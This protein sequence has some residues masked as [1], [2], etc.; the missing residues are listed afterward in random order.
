MGRGAYGDELAAIYSFS[1]I[2]LGLLS[3]AGSGVRVGD[4]TTARSWQ[5]PAS[6]GLLLH[7]DTEEIRKYF[8]A[9]REISVFGNESEL[10]LRISE[11]LANKTLREAIRIEG[12]ERC[13]NAPYTYAP[14]VKTVLEYHQ[15]QRPANA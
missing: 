6:G 9:G 4:M 10:P 8:E 5:I 13:I 2:N 11:L 1:T 15:A 3:E 7:E 12:Y 14:A